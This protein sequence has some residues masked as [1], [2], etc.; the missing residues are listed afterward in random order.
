MIIRVPF[1]A[2]NAESILSPNGVQ[3]SI[4][5]TRLFV[6]NDAPADLEACFDGQIWLSAGAGSVVYPGMSFTKVRLRRAL[7]GRGGLPSL[8]AL[9]T[10]PTLRPTLFG[11]NAGNVQ[12]GWSTVFFTVSTDPIAPSAK[13]NTQAYGWRAATL[14]GTSASYLNLLELFGAEALRNAAGLEFHFYGNCADTNTAMVSPLMFK[15]IRPWASPGATAIY[16]S[17]HLAAACDKT[18]FTTGIGIEASATFHGPFDPH[19]LIFYYPS[20]YTFTESTFN[21]FVTIRLVNQC[22][23]DVC[24]FSVDG[25]ALVGGYALPFYQQMMFGA[26]SISRLSMIAAIS[27][28]VAGSDNFDL[29]TYSEPWSYPILGSTPA[30]WRSSAAA[31]GQRNIIDYPIGQIALCGFY[32]TNTANL[33]LANRCVTIS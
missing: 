27:A 7:V 23:R 18:T 10:M 25:A 3:L 31:V 21:D 15:H 28:F 20:S 1:F 19:A 30:V 16:D 9:G 12:T 22:K 2:P 4:A 29:H 32:I 8:S 17:I 11:G 14:V 24:R 33:T 6:S 13:K 26:P 5:G